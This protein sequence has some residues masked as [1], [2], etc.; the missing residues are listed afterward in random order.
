MDIKEIIVSKVVRIPDTNCILEKGEIIVP[1]VEDTEIPEG[2]DIVELSNPLTITPANGSDPYLFE[3]GEKFYVKERID[4][5]RKIDQLL[6]MR[7][8]LS[9]F[10]YKKAMYKLTGASEHPFTDYFLYKTIPIVRYEI[11]EE[12]IDTKIQDLLDRGEI[13][14]IYN[15]SFSR[16]GLGLVPSAI[17]PIVPNSLSDDN[18]VEFPTN[19]SPERYRSVR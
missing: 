19:G 6:R 5:I 14:K 9:Y 12:S 1:I 2:V 18:V 13:H 3:T 7:N 11:V 4:K 10:T 8:L 17:V 15:I 16:R